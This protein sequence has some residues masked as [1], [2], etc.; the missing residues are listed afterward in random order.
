[1]TWAFVISSYNKRGYIATYCDFGIKKKKK[2]FIIIILKCSFFKL[3]I[4]GEMWD[5]GL[6]YVNYLFYLSKIWEFVD[7]AV[8]IIKQKP[9][10][11]LQF[12]HHF[13]ALLTMWGLVV[14]RSNQTIVFVG[15]NR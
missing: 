10:S 13:G 11:M 8:L 2:K 1:M 15:L 12:Y 3:I 4:D 7:T 6:G 5:N 9:V 14:A